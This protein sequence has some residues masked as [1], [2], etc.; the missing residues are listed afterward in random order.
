MF[1]RGVYWFAT[2]NNMLSSQSSEQIVRYREPPGVEG[3]KAPGCSQQ[4]KEKGS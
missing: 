1:T 3:A 2:A 4:A